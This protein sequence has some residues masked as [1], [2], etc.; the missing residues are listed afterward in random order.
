MDDNSRD[1]LR[2]EVRYWREA[3]MWM[4][5]VHAANAQNAAMIKS[6]SKSERR[7]QG[8]IA[9]E[10]SDLLRE[11]TMPRI[12]MRSLESIAERC[13]DAARECAD[14]KSADVHK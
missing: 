11:I 7:R 4:A 14:P 13:T 5:D 12:S 10:C 3:A 1:L 2:A 9:Q 8:R 6:T